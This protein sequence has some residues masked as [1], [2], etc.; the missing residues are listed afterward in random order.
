MVR[1]AILLAFVVGLVSASPLVPLAVKRQDLGVRDPANAPGPLDIA[2]LEAEKALNETSPDGWDRFVGKT[3]VVTYI[4][5]E[6]NEVST[7]PPGLAEAKEQKQQELDEAKKRKDEDDAKKKQE[8]KE[9]EDE[10]FCGFREFKTIEDGTRMIDHTRAVWE[11]DD[12][13]YKSELAISAA[14]A[15]QSHFTNGFVFLQ[16]VPRAGSAV[17]R[18]TSSAS[19]STQWQISAAAAKCMASATR[20]P[21]TGTVASI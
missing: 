8:D 13:I 1:P 20:A 18:R 7:D 9:K 2:I 11:I 16:L 17:I 15:P 10:K 19:I 5:Q 3:G 12:Y 14:A 6:T 21:K 4:N